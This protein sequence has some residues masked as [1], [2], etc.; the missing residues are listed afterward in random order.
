MHKVKDFRKPKHLSSEQQEELEDHLH[1][2]SQEDHVPCATA[3]EIAKSLGIPAD[4]V[5]K[6]ANKL[7]IR[8]KKCLLDCF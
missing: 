2:A 8:I 6:T 4:D 3:L 7:N 1:K 5:G